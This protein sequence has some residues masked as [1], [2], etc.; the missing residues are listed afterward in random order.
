ML[1]QIQNI[2]HVYAQII[3]SALECDGL[4][5]TIYI[6]VSNEADS[7][8]SLKI[9]TSLLKSDEVQFVAIPV[10]SKRTL[11]E[12]LKKLNDSQYLRSMVFINCGGTLDMTR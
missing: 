11:V 12:E 3:N 2:K 8:A 9:L 10:F 4:G 7:I 6:F 1:I 5:C